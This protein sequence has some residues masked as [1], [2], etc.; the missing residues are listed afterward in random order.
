MKKINWKQI[1]KIFAFIL[2]TTLL[3]A[4]YTTSVVYKEWVPASSQQP[5]LY[6]DFTLQYL[7]FFTTQSNIIVALWFLVAIIKDK[8]EEENLF[9]AQL[10]KIFV[11]SYITI[12]MLVWAGILLPAAIKDMSVT[13]WIF[14]L[15]LHIV[16]PILMISYAIWTLGLRTISFAKYFKKAFWV[17]LSYPLLYLFYVSIRGV[18]RWNDNKQELS[19]PYPFLNFYTTYLGMNGVIA[20]FLFIGIILVLFVLLNLLYILISNALAKRKS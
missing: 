10:G 12:T 18:M 11:T 4:S 1:I 16:V 14:G 8:K 19:F 5:F 20:F 17:Y 15:G 13:G 9:T 2:T 7:S 6:G 3:I